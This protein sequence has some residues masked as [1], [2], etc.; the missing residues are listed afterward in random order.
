MPL[1]FQFCVDF[2][3]IT[4]PDDPENIWFAANLTILDIGLFSAG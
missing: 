1:A 3:A 4:I 2:E